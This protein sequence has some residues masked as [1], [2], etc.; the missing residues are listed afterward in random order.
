MRKVSAAYGVLMP[1]RGVA[2][3]TT[4]IIDK[5]GRIAHIDEGSGAIDPNGA[6]QAC[7][8]VRK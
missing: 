2:N 5:D 1:E 8:R 7:K 4:F 3:R 6:L